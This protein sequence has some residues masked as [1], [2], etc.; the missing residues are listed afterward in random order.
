LGSTP[1]QAARLSQIA[2]EN[3][4]VQIARGRAIE[5]VRHAAQLGS[6]PFHRPLPPLGSVL[7]FHTLAHPCALFERGLVVLID[8]LRE[9]VQFMK[10]FA[11]IARVVLE[12]LQ[13]A[14]E[15]GLLLLGVL[16]P[17]LFLR[18]VGHELVLLVEALWQKPGPFLARIRIHLIW[19]ETRSMIAVANPCARIVA[20]PNGQR[21]S[22]QA[23]LSKNAF[24]ADIA[25]ATFPADHKP[26]AA[27]ATRMSTNRLY[28]VR[29][30]R[31]RCPH[32][33]RQGASSNAAVAVSATTV[34]LPFRWDV[35]AAAQLGTLVQGDRAGTCDGFTRGLLTCCARM[36]AS[37]RNADLVFVGRSPESLHD[38]LSGLLRDTSWRTRLTLLQFSVGY[39]ERSAAC[40]KSPESL[41]AFRAY[42]DALGLSPAKLIV[43]ERPVSL[44]DLVSSGRTLHQLLLLI[45]DW[46]QKDKADWPAVQRKIRV[47]AIVRPPEPSLIPTWK[48]RPKPWLWR[49]HAL[50]VGQ[51]LGRGATL[52]QVSAD[53][54]LWSFLADYQEKT[55]RSYVPER[56][57]DP[58]CTVPRSA[59]ERHLRALRLARGLFE[60]GRERTGREAFAAH[61]SQQ[62]EMRSEW[63]RRLVQEVRARSSGGTHVVRS[64]AQPW[65]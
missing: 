61:L 22:C 31:P 24:G 12:P 52:R 37:A 57:G 38:L 41:A 8:P 44:V 7:G 49:E 56:W 11:Q 4:A 34:P 6:N 19:H 21:S 14:G 28:P 5:S 13:Q 65:N 35:T 47:V 42:L 60:Q 48:R 10:R 64:V 20:F 32:R 40:R 55:I 39:T 26:T 15:L 33:L 18:V 50:W 27:A 45:R 43:R 16:P 25:T 53:R 59:D 36:V 1:E 58:A 29:P 46:A 9:R 2:I 3:R 54:A 62:R 17:V 23:V 30:R 51:L 63:L